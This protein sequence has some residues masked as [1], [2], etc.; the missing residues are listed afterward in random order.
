VTLQLISS[1]ESELTGNNYPDIHLRTE[2][3]RDNDNSDVDVVANEE[4]VYV[5]HFLIKRGSS[6]SG[7][8]SFNSNGD[9]AASATVNGSVEY[10]SS[11]LDY[12]FR[13]SSG[14]NA[15]GTVQMLWQGW[16]TVPHAANGTKTL[17]YAGTWTGDSN[18]GSKSHSSSVVLPTIVAVPNVPTAVAGAR[19][20]DTQVTVSWA[21]SHPS[22]GAAT[23]NE[24]QQR[25]NGGAETDV[26]SISPTTSV[27]VAAAANRKTE[28]RVRATNSAGS[29]AWSAWS[30]PVYTTPGAPTGVTATKV[31]SDIQLG[32]TPNVA[33]AEHEHVIEHGV[34]VAG[35]I[36]WDGSDLADVTAGTSTYTDVAPNPAQR[37]VYRI[38]ARNTDV[39]ALAS[40]TSQSN[41]VVLLTAPGK[42]A[43]P[44]PPAFADKAA[45]FRFAWAHNPIDSS[46]QTKRQVRY[47]LDGGGSWTTGAKT[48]STDQFLD[49]AG[50]TWVANDAVT[51]QVRTKGAYDSGADGDASYSPWS[52]SVTVTFKTKPVA[53]ITSPADT[54]T[55]TEAELT[56]V[57]GFAQAEAATFVS[58]DLRLYD[59]TAALLEQR[60]ST[61]L[62]GTLFDTR[63]V[64][65]ESYTLTVTV[66]DSN[67]LVSA[68]VSSDFDVDYVEPVPAVVE[69]TYLELSGIMQLAV[70]IAAAGG[71]YVDATTVSI[72]RVI[73][74]VSEPVVTAYPADSSL[75]FLDTT[76]TIHGTNL[77]RV[78]TRSDDGATS[79]V[80]VSVDVAEN[81]WAFLSK[82]AGYDTIV[83][84]ELAPGEQGAPTVD[85]SLFKASGRT[86]PIG[87]YA[88]T[89]DL[90]VTATGALAAGY[91]S[92]PA[93]VEELL[94]LPGKGCYRSPSGRRV[95]GRV[96]GSTTASDA[97]LAQL[98]FTI[99]ETD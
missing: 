80:T 1:K 9:C 83:R 86:R 71:G 93:E 47:S 8:S 79:V 62:A 75:T 56:A 99:T 61:T 84:F 63:L 11:G 90:A 42:P 13:S 19:V 12:D 76:P 46:A 16:V 55:V 30:A 82:G 64:D 14:K 49:F 5:K 10:S 98:A 23:S 37:H 31:G 67:G 44:P 18:L 51:F 27:N 26:A 89:G 2:V 28:Y 85:S 20:S 58:A 97:E 17:T 57:L 54:S 6:G 72:T 70:T 73:D 7:T 88:T 34:D 24:V 81:R 36:T 40:T 65:G 50:G 59:D 77:Y 74:G 91:S 15:T 25:V 38:R 33:F 35:V 32:W 52:D 96:V 92:T 94:A 48:T 41:V 68:E 29:S 53:T 69:A 95:F 78:T 45:T 3:W 4:D 21:Q 43:V 22:N 60:T 87:Q 66:T 39:A